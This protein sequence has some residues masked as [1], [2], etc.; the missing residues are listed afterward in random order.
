MSAVKQGR[1]GRPEFKPTAAQRRA[2]S[3]AAGAG[4]THEEIAIGMGIAR[5]TLEKHFQAELSVVAYQRRLE[6]LGAMHKSAMKGSVAAQKAYIALTP[7]AAA[8]PIPKEEPMGKKAQAQADAVSAEK[9]TEWDD[10]I[11]VGASS[12]VVALRQGG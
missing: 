2:V 11:G 12:N 9:G 10:L 8:P 5:N 7:A 1:R 4:M 6:V 3:I